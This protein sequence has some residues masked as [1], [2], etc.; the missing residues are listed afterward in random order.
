VRY[1]VCG[2]RLETL[3]HT[4]Y[5]TPQTANTMK[6]TFIAVKI[7]VGEELKE[8]ISTLKSGLRNENIKWADLNN[9]HVTLA[10]I[11]DTEKAVIKNIGSMLENEFKGSG[12]IEFNLMGFGLFRNINNPRIIFSAVQDPGKLTEAHK[13]IKRELAVM[14]ITLEER[15]FNP[16]LTIG[17]IK[18]LGDKNNLKILVEQYAGKILQKVR[19]SE[20]IYFESVLLPTGPIYKPISKVTL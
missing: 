5:R 1:A 17:R 16:H 6:R 9:F 15:E 4:A 7:D 12:S 19:V 14:D 8:S 13:I 18:D 10:F 3:P 2:M 11:G 20:I